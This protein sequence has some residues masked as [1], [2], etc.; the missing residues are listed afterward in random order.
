MSV[1]EDELEKWLKENLKSDPAY[2]ERLR[3][4]AIKEREV[5]EKQRGLDLQ[6]TQ[7]ESNRKLREEMKKR[8]T[9]E[10]VYPE[11]VCPECGYKNVLKPRGLYGLFKKL[12]EQCPSRSVYVPTEISKLDRSGTKDGWIRDKGALKALEA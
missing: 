5:E 3:K 8:F 11:W 9:G 2:I 7:E 4:T 10:I 6:R 12:R 1:N